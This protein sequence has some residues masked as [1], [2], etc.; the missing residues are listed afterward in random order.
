MVMGALVV[1]SCVVISDVIGCQLVG[2]GH[3]LRVC[4]RCLLLLLGV[5][6]GGGVCEEVSV[7]GALELLLTATLGVDSSRILMMTTTRGDSTRS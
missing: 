5:V 2:E 6:Y 1:L 7:A 4:Q 3:R